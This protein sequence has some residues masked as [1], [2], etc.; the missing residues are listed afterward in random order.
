MV[1][2]ELIDR[3]YS[4]SHDIREYIVNT[5][6]CIMYWIDVEEVQRFIEEYPDDYE[7]RFDIQLLTISATPS[8]RITFHDHP[9]RV[10]SIV[11]FCNLPTFRISTDAKWFKWNG[12]IKELHMEGLR[13]DLEYFKK[14]VKETE[15]LLKV[16]EQSYESKRIDD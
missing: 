12:R 6:H 11:R 4:L 8:V 1:A 16:E 13:A 7:D 14:K 9:D 2:E 3:Y 15:E 5:P 10:E